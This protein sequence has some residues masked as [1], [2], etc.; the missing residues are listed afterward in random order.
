MGENSKIEWT[1]RRGAIPPDLLVREFP[2][3]TAAM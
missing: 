1:D 2:C 3:R